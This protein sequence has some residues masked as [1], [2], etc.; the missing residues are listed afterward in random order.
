MTD[1]ADA[2]RQQGGLVAAAAT[3][4]PA[5]PFVGRVRELWELLAAL[6][7]AA[8]HRDQL[9]LVTGEPGIGK[10]RLMEELAR[11]L[12]GRCWW[13]WTTCTRPTRRRCSCSGSWPR[14][15]P[16]SGW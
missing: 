14:P 15:G 10:S 1:A 2:S 9:F 12:E 4:Q 6:R 7:E 5:R 16:T 3:G 8:A 11:L 13:S